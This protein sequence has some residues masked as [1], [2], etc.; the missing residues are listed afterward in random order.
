M[1]VLELPKVPRVPGFKGDKGV[2]V[3]RSTQGEDILK[4]SSQ[5]KLLKKVQLVLHCDAPSHPST[6]TEV[7]K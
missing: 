2:L 4:N 6:L 1:S 3:K 7:S 5:I